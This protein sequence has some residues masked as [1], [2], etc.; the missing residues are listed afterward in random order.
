MT[1]TLIDC[2]KSYV[3][4]RPALHP[5]SLKIGE[6]EIVSLLGPSGCGKT[7][8]LRVIAEL[9]T[10]D[11]GGT[12]DFSGEDV[13]ALAVERRRIGI[14][15]QNYAL[16]PNMTLEGNI[17]YGLRMQNLPKA[18][19]RSRLDEVLTLC[20]LQDL[21]LRPVTALSG[22]QRQR[23]ALARAIAPRPRVLLLDEPLS[24]L[25]AALRERLRDE[26]AILLRSF[27]ITSVFVTHDQTEALAISDRIAV[28][29]DGR[30]QQIGTP[31]DLYHCPANAFVAGFV[32]SAQQLHGKP[33]GEALALAGG[34]L[35][36]G[37]PVEGRSVW[38]RAE[39]IHVDPEGPLAGC[40]ETATFL[41]DHTRLALSGV[42]S[43][44]LAV[45]Y[46]GASSPRPGEVVRLAI[47]PET[48][49]VL[50]SAA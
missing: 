22:G 50:E 40:V 36:V 44:L 42:V 1:L 48:L 30:I 31:E 6:G 37:R 26:L 14:V 46:Q 7:T 17:A 23:V 20:Q 27:A 45:R 34:V 5:T 21:R 39:N 28:M 15:F 43:G 38:V 4:G 16:F 32:G 18:E 11:P 13:T 19:I 29:Q 25:D 3:P 47:R 33:Q 2:A 8:L 49:L 9:E 10:C 24:A 41:G 35:P 12:V